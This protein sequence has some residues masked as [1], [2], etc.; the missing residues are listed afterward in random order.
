MLVT[1]NEVEVDMYIQ[2]H[3]ESYMGG[4]GLHEEKLTLFGRPLFKI[5]EF[6][7]VLFF[8]H[9]IHHMITGFGTDLLGEAKLL[10]WE[11]GAGTPWYYFEKYSKFPLIFL[12]MPKLAVETYKLGKSQNSLY[13]VDDAVLRSKSLEEVE[14][15]IEHGK[16]PEL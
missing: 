2:K 13:D 3:L 7:Q 9:D 6:F 1:H 5:P 8:K 10:C 16:F 12:F 15:Y 11:V 14:H 4:K